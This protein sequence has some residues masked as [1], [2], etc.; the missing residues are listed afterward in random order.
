VL[1]KVI[2]GVAVA[3]LAFAI[4]VGHPQFKRYRVPSESMQPTIGHDEIVNLNGGEAPRVGDIVIFHGPEGAGDLAGADC[5]E[6]GPGGLCARSKPE[7]S[8]TTF[9]K[10]IVAGPGDR[11]TFRDGQSIRNGEPVDEPYIADC[12]SGEAC[13]YPQPV[14]VPEGTYYLVG[15]N[16][17]ASEDSRFWGPV[18]EGWILGRAERCSAIYFFC[19]PA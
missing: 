6:A 2:L 16:R 1:L 9:I 15:D 3:I 12:G 13:T 10:R 5:A 7:P 18:P 11:I 4:V 17:G 14:T 8:S 19:S